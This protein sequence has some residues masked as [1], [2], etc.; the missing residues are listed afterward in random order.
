MQ[1]GWI[2]VD[3]YK[4]APSPL[5]IENIHNA[6]LQ[7]VCFRVRCWHDSKKRL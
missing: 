5:F 2:T 7:I 1:D 3:I 6:L 4:A